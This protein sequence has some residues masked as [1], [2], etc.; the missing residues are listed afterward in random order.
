M[1]SAANRFDFILNTIPV[2]HDVGPYVN[3]LRPN[4]VMVIVGAIDFTYIADALTPDERRVVSEA[5][6]APTS[7]TS[8]RCRSRAR[9][10]CARPATSTTSSTAPAA[11]RKPP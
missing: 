6:V 8:T 11:T 7:R 10:T 4:G 3:L 5:S 1:A 2:T 9:S